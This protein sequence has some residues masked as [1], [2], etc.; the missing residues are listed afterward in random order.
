MDCVCAEVY[1]FLIFFKD[2][3]Y[4]QR[5]EKGVRKRGRETS[6]CERYRLL[7]TRAQLGTWPATQACA[8][9]WK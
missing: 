2:V 6:V 1:H 9:A 4:V 5:G 3:I 7:L 8:L